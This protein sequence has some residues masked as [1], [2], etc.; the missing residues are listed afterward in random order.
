MDR[1]H[2]GNENTTRL[3]HAIT[4]SLEKIVSPKELRASPRESGLRIMEQIC[5]ELEVTGV[6]ANASRLAMLR[7][8]LE[9]TV[10]DGKEHGIYELLD[11]RLDTFLIE[12]LPDKPPEM[13]NENIGIASR[14]VTAEPEICLQ[15]PAGLSGM[16][17]PVTLFVQSFMLLVNHNRSVHDPIYEE[18][19]NGYILG[20]KLLETLYVDSNAAE[21]KKVA[22]K[23]NLPFSMKM[24]K[25][26]SVRIG[27]QVGNKKA[28]KNK[29]DSGKDKL[30][31]TIKTKSSPKQSVD[32][33]PQ[34]TS[35][36][37]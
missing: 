3:R 30:V 29:L 19:Y 2:G 23:K 15:V 24:S 31:R 25:L 35:K 1:Q 33:N 28:K 9:G 14:G 27:D 16:L 17:G 26:E 18:L 21:T 13:L 20:G 32:E 34:N 12:S 36:Q 11:S 22:P 4:C 8:E 10:N 5:V 7:R 37:N 6:T